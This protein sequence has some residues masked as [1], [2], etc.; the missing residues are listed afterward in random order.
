MASTSKAAATKSI[1]TPSMTL[2]GHGEVIRS[3]SYVADGQQMISGSDDKTAR[4]W[5]LKA[6]REIEGARDGGVGMGR[7]GIKG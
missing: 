1:L 5:D 3:I 6:G 4:Q 2:K 7:G